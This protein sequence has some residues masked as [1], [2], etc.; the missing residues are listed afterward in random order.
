MPKVINELPAGDSPEQ[1][2]DPFFCLLDD[3]SLV[4]GLSVRTDRLLEPV[5]NSAE[6][7]LLVHVRTRVTE[8]T[9]LNL[10]MG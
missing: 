10:G 9:M 5:A 8:G 1:N 4:T 6:A 2:E 7:Q 3:D